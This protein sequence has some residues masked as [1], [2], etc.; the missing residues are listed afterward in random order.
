MLEN[1]EL[2]QL[3]KAWPIIIIIWVAMFVTL[4]MYLGLCHLGVHIEINFSQDFTFEKLR[5]ILFGVSILTLIAIHFVRKAMM[6][7]GNANASFHSPQNQL[8]H[9]AFGKY[10][11]AIIVSMVLSE[12]IGIYGLVLFMV[13]KDWS[14]LYLLI[15]I[16]AFAMFYFRPKKEELLE[17]AT[18]MSRQAVTEF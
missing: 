16:S 2:E 17:L 9:P 11:T 5:S 3:N 4:C 7:V 13:G 15:F 6:R 18:E 12:S 8:Q 14:S 1:S 10:F